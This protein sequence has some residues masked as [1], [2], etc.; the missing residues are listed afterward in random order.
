MQSTQKLSCQQMTR[1]TGRSLVVTLPADVR[2]AL[3][4][5]G[6]HVVPGQ[7]VG[8]WRWQ[9]RRRSGGCQAVGVV[10][11]S[12]IG[13][14]AGR[15]TAGPSLPPAPDPVVVLPSPAIAAATASVT[16]AWKTLGMM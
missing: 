12:S 2:P 9:T 7:R 4:P 11:T 16:S 8:V 1:A 10:P 14:T 3:N 15:V 6:A 5:G 13:S